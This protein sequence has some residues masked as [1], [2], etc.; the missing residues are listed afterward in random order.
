MCFWISRFLKEKFPSHTVHCPWFA[1]S[2]V[3]FSRLKDRFPSH[4]VHCPW[5]VFSNVH[6]VVHITTTYIQGTVFPPIQ[7]RP[8]TPIASQCIV[9]SNFTTLMELCVLAGNFSHVYMRK[10]WSVQGFFSPSTVLCLS[11]FLLTALRALG[12]KYTRV[13]YAQDGHSVCARCPSRLWFSH[14]W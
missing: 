4:T 3:Q 1:L 6:F 12:R 14:S 10:T 5:F 8:S 7:A 13:R 2:N 11:V 9:V